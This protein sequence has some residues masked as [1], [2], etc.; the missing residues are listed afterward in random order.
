MIPKRMT[1]VLTAAILIIMGRV[2]RTGSAVELDSYKPIEI[3]IIAP[4]DNTVVPTGET[5]VLKC[6]ETAD[7]L[8]LYYMRLK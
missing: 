4:A 3:S 7:G 2:Q 6:K 5:V 8:Y 1:W